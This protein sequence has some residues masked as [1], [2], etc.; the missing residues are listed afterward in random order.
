M[1][2]TP[3]GPGPLIYGHRG[4]RSRAADN[5]IEAYRLAV[6]AGA[7]GIELDVRRT[8]DGVL[9]VHHNDRDDAVGVFSAMTFEVLRAMAP[10]VPTLREAM[11]AIPPEIFVNVEIKNLPSDAGFDETRS[12]VDDTITELRS[13][14]TPSRILLSSFDPPSMERAGTVAPEFLRGQLVASPIGLDVAVAFATES[15]MQA[16]N[17]SLAQV[18]DEPKST[19]ARIHESG[20]A[21]VVWA[22]NTTHDVATMADAGVDVIITDDP[23]LARRVIDQM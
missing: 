19:V 20:L 21:V 8:L 22:V 17:P 10:Q 11:S 1:S 3:L 14:D 9:I 4:D 16:V 6:E 7:H 12:I 5:T 2:T 15:G 23:A 18:S 13:N